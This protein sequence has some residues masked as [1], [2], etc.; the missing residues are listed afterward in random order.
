MEHTTLAQDTPIR[1]EAPIKPPRKK[2]KWL[3]R[4]AVSAALILILALAMN[5]CA[6]QGQGLLAASYLAD[7]AQR[8]DMLVSVS[9]TGTLQP[10]DSYK[11]TALVKGEI[12][13]APFEEGQVVEKDALLFQVDAG[14]AES[15]ISRAQLTVEQA[16]LA[17]QQL[18]RSQ[19]DALLEAN[20][21]GVVQELFFE[22]GDNVT[23]GSVVATI[24]DNTTMKL[25]VPFHTADA[26]SFTPGQA[27]TVAVDGTT[28][29]LTGTVEAVSATDSVGQGG[30]LIR[31]VTL[32]VANPGALDVTSTGTATVNGVTCAASGTFEYAAHKQVTAKTSG[33][34]SQFHVKEGDTVTKGQ[35]L[36]SFAGDAISD[37]IENARL[38][39]QSAQLSLDSA[40]KA[41]DSYTLTAPISGTIIEKNYKAG[42]N[43]DPSSA[44]QTSAMAVIYDM[45]ALTFDMNVSELDIGSIVPGQTV[46]VTAQA[47]PGQ[48]FH[49][50][51][52]RVSVNGSTVNGFTTYPATILLED[53]GN[54][55]PGMN[56]SA[57]IIVEQAKDV[58]CVP[59]SAVIRGDTVLVPGEGAMGP[60]GLT[61]ADPTKVESRPVTLGRSDDEYIE[62]TSGLEEGDTVLIQTTSAGLSAAGQTMAV[63]AASGG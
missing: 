35:L 31:N 36:A 39:L 43:V 20:A 50:V 4:L 52:S 19:K 24:L 2:K 25:T 34:L 30:T 51:V 28:E 47:L 21:D 63:S 60:D 18:L 26:V 23:A 41:L 33:E 11:V 62:I 6:G 27:A 5:R 29:V 17:Y 45:S 58:L 12:L 1:E 44:A 10:I 16:E 3:K 37:Q 38:S 49:G 46:S 40:R 59:V 61:V 57:E 15:S 9:G 53:Y 54:L 14:D 32:R 22:A 55:K 56:V 8:R 13:E 42:D 48:V 7:T